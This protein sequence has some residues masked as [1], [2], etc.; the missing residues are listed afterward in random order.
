ML[1]APTLGFDTIDAERSVSADAAA[2]PNAQLG[3]QEDYDGSQI[4][5]S[6]TWWGGETVENQI[7][8]NVTN[9]IGNPLSVS[10]EVSSVQWTDGSGP[11]LEVVNNDEFLDPMATNQTRAV[12]LGC[13]QTVG[14]DAD[15]ATVEL[16]Y[17]A[18]GDPV[19]V[20]GATQTIDEV[21]FR[22]EGAAGGQPPNDPIPI[23][24]SRIDLELDGS[25]SS[26]GFASSR[27]AFSVRNSG[28]SSATISGIHVA[29]S[30][31]GTRVQSYLDYEV[32]ITGATTDG[33]LEAS[34]GLDVGPDAP[35]Y[36][37]DQDAV[38][39]NDEVAD[40][41]VGSFQAGSGFSHVDMSGDT[42]TVVLMVE[43]LDVTDRE[44]PVPVEM[45]ITVP[46]GG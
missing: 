22:C 26:E 24:D 27:V 2:N 11:A 32:D 15:A 35:R 23:N 18:T 34:N 28:S 43:E 19:S 7:V 4:V 6:Q 25:P 42:V 21:E 20:E 12:R 30:S 14:G 1:L 9:R 3:L 36:D 33:T 10:V 44:D 16:A 40:V 39:G 31:S 45:T 13:S 41:S 37:L 17:D 46:E 38:I 5:Y 29:N 8:A